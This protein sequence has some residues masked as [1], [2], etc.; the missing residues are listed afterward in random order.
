[1]S[2]NFTENRSHC[3]WIIQQAKELNALLSYQSESMLEAN[4]VR[5]LSCISTMEGALKELRASIENAED[6]IGN[7]H[8]TERR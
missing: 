5:A 1:M 3:A 8:Q 7:A 2:I 6:K 4:K